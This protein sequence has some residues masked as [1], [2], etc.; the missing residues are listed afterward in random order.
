MLA[1]GK[2]ASCCNAETEA[3]NV[4]SGGE[5]PEQWFW[6]RN[7][8]T[9]G[10]TCVAAKIRAKK[11]SAESLESFYQNDSPFVLKLLHKFQ[12]QKHVTMVMEF[13]QGGSLFDIID[14]SKRPLS[15]TEGRIYAAE[16]IC[17]VKHLHGI[18]QLVLY[19]RK[20]E[21]VRYVPHFL[22][23][24]KYIASSSRSGKHFHHG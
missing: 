2:F 22:C 3:A 8:G 16:I 7:G 21:H 5:E 13:G 6:E 23:R 12:D 9:Y 11:Y 19:A 18:S 20:S 15:H 24:S 14:N 17:G 10:L 1:G 4:D